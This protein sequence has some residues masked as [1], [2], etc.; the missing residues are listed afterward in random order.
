MGVLLLLY[1]G[2]AFLHLH[3]TRATAFAEHLGVPILTHA[4]AWWHVAANS[5]SSSS[6]QRY[7]SL[8]S[9]DIHA[10]TILSV[11]KDGEVMHQQ[12]TGLS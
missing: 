8:S 2:S 10:T 4:S 3:Q 12:Q 7:H 5:A 11:R 9:N 1:A 6:G